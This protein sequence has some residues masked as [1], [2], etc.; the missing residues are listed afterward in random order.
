MPVLHPQRFFRRQ[1]CGNQPR[2]L[3]RLPAAAEIRMGR[4]LMVP[5][6]EIWEPALPGQNWHFQRYT[7]QSKFSFG[8]GAYDRIAR[9]LT[10]ACLLYRSKTNIK[11]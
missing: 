11:P 9:I 6:F 10:T 3:R 4:G 8:L 5:D 1:S 7:L 2:Q